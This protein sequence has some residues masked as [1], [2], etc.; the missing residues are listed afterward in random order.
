MDIVVDKLDVAS[1]DRVVEML[2]AASANPLR[3]AVL[4]NLFNVVP[5]LLYLMR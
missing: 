2:N 3:L 1:T 4:T 5:F